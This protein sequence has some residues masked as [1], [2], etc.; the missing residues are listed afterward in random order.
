MNFDIEGVI[1]GSGP[2]STPPRHPNESSPVSPAELDDLL[3]PLPIP[4]HEVLEAQQEQGLFQLETDTVNQMESLLETLWDFK[5]RW[6]QR[7]QLAA[8]KRHNGLN[9]L[10]H[11]ARKTNLNGI[12][13]WTVAQSYYWTVTV[14]LKD[15]HTFIENLTMKKA[16]HNLSMH[17]LYCLVLVISYS[18]YALYPSR[19]NRC[20]LWPVPVKSLCF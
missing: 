6:R 10:W 3:H 12:Q 4:H 18:C 16:C 1:T 2:S 15:C 8:L 11:A 9:H 20:I 5:T 17:F 19:L 14:T 7:Q 13:Q